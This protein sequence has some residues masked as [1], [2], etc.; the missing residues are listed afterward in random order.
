M[1]DPANVFYIITVKEGQGGKLQLLLARPQDKEGTLPVT[2]YRTGEAHSP[3]DAGAT[4]A[5]SQV[6]VQVPAQALWAR[7]QPRRL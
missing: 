4:A 2:F 3:E 1:K 7:Q 6:A 5:P